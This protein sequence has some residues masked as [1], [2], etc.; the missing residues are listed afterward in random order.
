MGHGYN[1]NNYHIQYSGHYPKGHFPFTGPLFR[2]P[3]PDFLL[4]YST[5]LS[6]LDIISS[7]YHWSVVLKKRGA[8][9]CSP[10]DNDLIVSPFAPAQKPGPHSLC[11]LPAATILL[12]NTVATDTNDVTFGW[13]NHSE[14]IGI[15]VFLS[16]PLLN[17][18]HY[19]TPD[20]RPIYYS[21][22]QPIISWNLLSFV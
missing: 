2:L 4:H 21:V 3:T 18:P 6:L 20:C 22:L 9:P 14:R 17:F 11:K 15:L 8:R 13:T 12:R 7:S 1:T 19:S 16:R 5:S 10:S